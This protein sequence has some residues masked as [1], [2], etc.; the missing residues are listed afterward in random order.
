MKALYAAGGA[1]KREDGGA[2]PQPEP[3]RGTD[4]EP[5]NG[6]ADVL[7]GI[8][9]RHERISNNLKRR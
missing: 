9:E 2:E 5:D 4:A 6:A 3:A 1:K 8:I 7:A